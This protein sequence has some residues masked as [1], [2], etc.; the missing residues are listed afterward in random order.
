LFVANT[1]NDTI[2]TIP[3]TG[4]TLEPGTPEVFVN[5]VGGGPD[6]LIIDETTTS[7][8]V[9]PVQRDSRARADA[10]PGDCRSATSRIDRDGAPIGFPAEY[11]DRDVFFRNLSPMLARPFRSLPTARPVSGR[12][13]GPSMDRGLSGEGHTSRRSRSGYRKV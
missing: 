10:G 2:V 7:G 11:P 13:C 3:V 12:I 1:A 5:R 4:S 9:Q 8:S 6:G